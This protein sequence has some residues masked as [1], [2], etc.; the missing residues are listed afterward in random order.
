[1][2]RK[3]EKF[4][5]K[6]KMPYHTNLYDLCHLKKEVIPNSENISIFNLK[7]DESDSTVFA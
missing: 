3:L 7:I 1:M 5:C 2:I 6:E 4:D